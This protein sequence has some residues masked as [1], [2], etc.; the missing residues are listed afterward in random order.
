MSPGRSR[1][2]LPAIRR[3]LGWLAPAALVAASAC[4]PSREAVAASCPPAGPAAEEITVQTLAERARREGTVRVIARLRLSDNASPAMAEAQD[5]AMALFTAAGVRE[6]ALVRDRLPLI[7][8][9]MNAEALES[10]ASNPLIESWSE[11]R[12]AVTTLSESAPLIGAPD[13]WRIGGRGAGQAVAILDTG[14]DSFHPFLAGRIVAEACFSTTSS[15]SGS[16]SVCPNGASSDLS[17]GSGRPCD[18]SGCEHGTHVAGIAAGR[19]S[20]VSGVAPD[21]DIIAV[22]VFSRFSGATCGGRSPCIASFTSDQIRALDFVA[23][24]AERRPIAAVNMSLGGGRSS[25]FCDSDLTKP[26]IDALRAAGVAT[27][28]ASGNDGFR[29]A[30][31]F[32]ACISSAVTV[33]ATSK[34][35]QLA[36]FSN[37]SPAVDLHAPGVSITSS[38]PNGQFV[39]FS[40][41]SMATPHVAGAFAA[42]RSLN[43]DASLDAIEA[44][45]KSAGVTVGGKPRI[46]LPET[47][48]LLQRSLDR[49]TRII[50]QE[51][52]GRTDAPAI[53]EA[54]RGLPGG[55]PVRLILRV[56]PQGQAAPKSSA[57]AMSKAEAAIRAAGVDTMERIGRQPLMV[58]EATPEQAARIMASGMIHSLAVDSVSTTQGAPD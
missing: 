52:T 49:E 40:G 5:S 56:L 4:V 50:A 43:P 22:Q 31:S 21:A 3:R 15:A 20:D 46:R 26:S 32:P 19:G 24:L 28:I 17:V 10:M 39:P 23:E 55:K 57:D 53:P 45:L 44:A 25:G 2:A 9:E 48:A 35:D 7:V 13:V 6:A 14:V 12:I 29:D 11:D 16:T 1:F 33:G 41:T 58:V 34:Q 36:R 8:A 47:N 42:L 30:V 51:N 37:C 18:V 27:A 54:L 38:V